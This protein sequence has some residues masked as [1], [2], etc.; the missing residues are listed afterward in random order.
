MEKQ[1]I[2]LFGVRLSLEY[3][4]EGKY[5]T[6]TRETPAEYPEPS[7]K[8]ITAFDSEEDVSPLLDGY[9]ETIYELLNEK[10]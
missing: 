9:I 3:V 5:Y 2:N 10:I 7:I 4:M 8:K 1:E 6:E